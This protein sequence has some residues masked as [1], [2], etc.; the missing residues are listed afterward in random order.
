MYPR[1][2]SRPAPRVTI[3]IVIAFLRPGY[4]CTCWPAASVTSTS[5]FPSVPSGSIGFPLFACGWRVS[6]MVATG[7][8]N[9]PARICDDRGSPDP[10]PPPEELPR[11][12]IC[13]H[14]LQIRQT[15]D[16]I[17]CQMTWSFRRF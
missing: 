17:R 8:I 7:G 5:A 15:M 6:I 1:Q 10:R 2:L 13:Q 16:R 4:G 3:R 14:N 12:F 9:P 11:P